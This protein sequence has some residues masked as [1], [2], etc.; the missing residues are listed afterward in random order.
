MG[1]AT[2]AR[3]AEYAEMGKVKRPYGPW[4]RT[5]MA[6]LRERGLL[7]VEAFISWLA[8]HGINVDR[9]LVSQ[10]S[11]GRSHL[12][13]DIL[14]RLAAFTGRPDQVF[15]DYVREVDCEVV[16][17]PRGNVGGRELIELMLEAGALLGRLQRA[18]IE[19]MSPGSPGG[20]EVTR[21]ER[22]E[23]RGRLDEL[24]QQLADVR[25]RLVR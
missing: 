4:S 16:R 1:R 9:T 22:S 3:G 13:A 18:L 8:E 6:S 2:Q 10:W 15:G 11:A 21:D 23:L 12:P 19:A 14:P 17:V 7:K 25:A 24:I 20:V 5:M